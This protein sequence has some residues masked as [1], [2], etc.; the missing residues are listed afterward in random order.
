M[1]AHPMG[2]TGKGESEI[3]TIR[4]RK[5]IAI[6]IRKNHPNIS[7]YLRSFIEYHHTRSHHKAKK[8]QGATPWKL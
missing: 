2:R 1:A 7:E 3:V 4:L 6:N 5:D 8:R